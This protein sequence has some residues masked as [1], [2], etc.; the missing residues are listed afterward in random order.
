VV[1]GDDAHGADAGEQSI[2]ELL[3]RSGKRVGDASGDDA[4]A[5]STWGFVPLYRGRKL[6]GLMVAELTEMGLPQLHTLSLSVTRALG[7]WD[8]RKQ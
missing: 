7:N 1:A 3:A 6:F 5:P 8:A 2:A 4:T